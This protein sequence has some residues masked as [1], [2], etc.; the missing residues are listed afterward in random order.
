M[1]SSSSTS[2][3]PPH[4]RVAVVAAVLLLQL[5][6][7]GRQAHS[8][9]A[10]SSTAAT[11]TTTNNP[12]KPTANNKPACSRERSRHARGV[13]D[14]FFYPVVVDKNKFTLPPNC[15]FDRAKDMYLEHERHKEVVRR[16]QWKS[17]YS[18]K[19]FRSEY[20]VDKHMDNRHMDKI[21]PDADVCLADYCEVLQ[22]DEHQAY[23]HPEARKKMGGGG[24]GGGRVGDHGRCNEEKLKG[25]RHF[26]E[27]LMNRCFPGSEGGR[28]SGEEELA[29]RLHEY[30][31]RHHCDLLTCEGAPR[32]FRIMSGHHAEFHRGA[33]LTMLIVLV[34]LL[35]LYYLSIYCWTKD[36][37]RMK[38][39]K[40]ARKEK[41]GARVAGALRLT[42]LAKTW[43]L[44]VV[45][46]GKRRK[47]KAY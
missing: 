37:R 14:E 47:H 18:D 7:L 2:M 19:V 39:L 20:Y 17:L 32:M 24:G 29:S 46:G 16:T 1:M 31:V 43:P 23:K 40:R 8:A 10:T 3:V 27:V 21:P 44:S 35:A 36:M 33:Y 15:P 42:E 13:L 9:E 30:F 26:C 41:M 4:R 5:A 34:V 22:C 25:V 11:T 38:D 6:L 28:G 45:F 12:S